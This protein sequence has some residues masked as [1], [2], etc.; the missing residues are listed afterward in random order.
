MKN[1]TV[2]VVCCVWMLLLANNVLASVYDVN[3]GDTIQD[4][5]DVAISG[6]TIIVSPGTYYENLILYGYDIVLTGTDPD[7]AAV[8]AST[9][10][11]GSQ[12][13]D[14]DNASV[15]IFEGSETADCVLG[16]NV[17]RW[18]RNN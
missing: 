11:D 16:I 6:D 5:I 3:P 15:I 10:I 17:D 4:A 18:C 14:T 7:S 9:I 1:L 12:Y 13:S 2:V 8:V